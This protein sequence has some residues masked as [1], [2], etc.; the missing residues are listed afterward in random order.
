MEVTE[1]DLSYDLF[2]KWS[3][4][5]LKEYCRKRGMPVTGTHKELAAMAYTAYRMKMPVELS[6]LEKIQL[7]KQQYLEKLK[8][9]NEHTLDDPLQDT[10]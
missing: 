9:P 8:L 4:D 3:S 6:S 2:M 1:E 7:A 5:A 10:A